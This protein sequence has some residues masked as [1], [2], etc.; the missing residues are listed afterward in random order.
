[1]RERTTRKRRNR[2][3]VLMRSRKKGK[4][5]IMMQGRRLI[6]RLIGRKKGDF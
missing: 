3:A 4:R 6:R 5:W 2:H 1:M